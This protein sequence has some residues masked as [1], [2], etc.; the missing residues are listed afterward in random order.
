MNWKRLITGL[1][2]LCLLT[3]VLLICFATGGF[4][5]RTHHPDFGRHDALTINGIFLDMPGPVA[6]FVF[7]GVGAVGLVVVFSMNKPSPPARAT[8]G[9]HLEDAAAKFPLKKS[10]AP[11]RGD[12]IE[13]H[14]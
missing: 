9:A 6:G 2:L 14:D 5:N 10:A 1:S 12:K 13:P 4:L 7:L 3:G 8:T 11:P